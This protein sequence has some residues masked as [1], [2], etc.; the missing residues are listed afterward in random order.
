MIAVLEFLGKQYLLHKGAQKKPLSGR[1]LFEKAV[2]ASGSPKESLL[3][4]RKAVFKRL[5]E[6]DLL[7]VETE[8]PSDIPKGVPLLEEAKELIDQIDQYLYL[9]HPLTRQDV[10]NIH[11]QAVM[12]YHT[13]KDMPYVPHT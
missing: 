2:M 6:V 5:Y 8:T 13:M 12:L 1:E 11:Q 7:H 4:F 10:E 9:G 3:L